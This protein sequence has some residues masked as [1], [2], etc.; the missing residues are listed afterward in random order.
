MKKTKIPVKK[1][2]WKS[3][4]RGL[5]SATHPKIPTTNDAFKFENKDIPEESYQKYIREIQ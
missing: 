3:F 5:S 1:N 4:T 2:R